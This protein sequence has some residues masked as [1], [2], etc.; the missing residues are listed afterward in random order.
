MLSNLKVKNTAVADWLKTATEQEVLAALDI[1]YI[2]LSQAKCTR[3]D[4]PKIAKKEKEPKEPLMPAVK[5]RLGET[6]V[7]SILSKHFPGLKNVSK[8]AKSADLCLYS[9]YRRFAIEVKN[10]SAAVPQAEVDKFTRDLST[11]DSLGG[12]FISLGSR[13]SNIK[14][15]AAV[16]YMRTHDRIIPCIYLVEPTEDTIVA[17]ANILCQIVG[18]FESLRLEEIDREVI[19]SAYH[20][21]NDGLGCMP[22]AR[23]QILTTSRD[24][25]EMLMKLQH[26]LI[27]IESSIR[28]GVTKLRRELINETIPDIEQLKEKFAQNQ[29]YVKQS[30]ETKKHVS[31]IL[32]K[33]YETIPKD[34]FIWSS[35]AN[36]YICNKMGF[37]FMAKHVDFIIERKIVSKSAIM[38]A[39]DLINIDQSYVKIEINDI[40][41]SWILKEI[42]SQFT[43]Q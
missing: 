3:T 43:S 36:K 12:L 19:V 34:K 26:E 31:D 32:V 35:S 9:D 42:A 33:I 24:I 1:G 11:T 7:Q 8:D 22:L 27:S 30:D 17:A 18:A 41:I 16:R 29:S 14:E 2:A 23:D 15:T 5:G 10:Y 28:S 4:S 25:S 37:S 6:A 20:N 38:S 40:S 13:I 39:Y 21:I